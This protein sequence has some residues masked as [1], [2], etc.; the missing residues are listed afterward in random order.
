MSEAAGGVQGIALH[1][2]VGE[3]EPVLELRVRLEIAG[4][5]DPV[6]LAVDALVEG[7]TDRLAIDAQA[8]IREGDEAPVQPE[9]LSVGVD[10]GHAREVEKGRDDLAIGDLVAVSSHRWI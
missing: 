10:V 5:G 9:P 8:E 4:L 7:S 2:G 6:Q 3:V 1:G